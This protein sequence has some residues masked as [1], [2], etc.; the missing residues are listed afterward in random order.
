MNVVI[1]PEPEPYSKTGIAWRAY[2]EN[3]VPL[4][5]GAETQEELRRRV[6]DNYPNA[7]IIVEGSEK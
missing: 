2:Q 4:Y 1:R 6:L 3:D 5:M 7:N